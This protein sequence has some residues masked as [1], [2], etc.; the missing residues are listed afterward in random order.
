MEEGSKGGSEEG[1]NR[2]DKAVKKTPPSVAKLKR[3][4]KI[5]DDSNL[6]SVNI[7]VCCLIMM[8]VYCDL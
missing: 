2:S 7:R 4:R 1:E 6:A 5:N 3:T 8:I